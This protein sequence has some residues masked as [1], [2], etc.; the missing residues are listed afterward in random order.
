MLL[1]QARHAGVVPR[2]HGVVAN[3]LQANDIGAGVRAS[4][5]MT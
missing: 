1:G 3:L 5:A 2:S 4:R